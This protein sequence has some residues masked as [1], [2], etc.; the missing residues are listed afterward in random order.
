[1][2]TNV[3]MPPRTSAPTVLPRAWIWKQR[4]SADPPPVGVGPAGWRVSADICLP[5]GRVA[6]G[7]TMMPA[8]PAPGKGRGTVGPPR[9]RQ[10][11]AGGRLAAACGAGVKRLADPAAAARGMLRADQRAGVRARRAEA[12][13]SAMKFAHFSHVWN[14]PEM[15]PAQRYEQLWRE[16]ALCDELGYDY[17]FAVEHHFRP[18]ESWMPS[19]PVYCTGAAARTRRLRIG[20]MGY[21]V[22]L[23][24]PLRIV[25]EAGVLDQVLNGRLELGLV[26][27]ITPD[28]FTHYQADFPNPP[29]LTHEGL[30]IL[31]AAFTSEGPFS[32][33]G[34]FH[35]YTD[36]TLSV[37]PLQQP[38][39]PMWIQSRDP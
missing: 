17:G 4:S 37:R 23:Y 30:G 16:L 7:G 25:E 3:V 34:A 5:A 20:P 28:Y 22:P 31:K 29:A 33:D 24:D 8:R 12:G 10:G 27:G 1:M 26:S 19:P 35:Q 13:G 21:I 38:H 11:L 9:V 6:A 39:P 15:T 36:V 2:T 18:Y 14:R 32:Y